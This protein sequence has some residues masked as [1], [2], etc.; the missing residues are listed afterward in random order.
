MPTDTTAPTLPEALGDA[1]RAFIAGPHRLLIG[2]ERPKAADGRT[3]ATLDPATGREIAH[4]PHAGPADVAGALAAARAA[5]ADGPW[6]SMPA[7]GRE[8]I[9]FALAQTIED[10]AQELAEIE[11]LDNG[12]PVNLARYVD[13]AGTIAHLRYF[14]GWPTK[15]EG[16]VLPVTAPNMHC[17]TR[18][19]PVGVCAQIV[20]W[21]F[22]L[23]MAAWKIAPALAAGC[24]VVLKPAEQTPL[25]ALRLGELALEAGL[26]PGVLNVLTGDGSTGAALVEHPEVDKIAFTGSTAVG[27]EIGSKAGQALKRVTLELGGK[28]PNI[29]LP[30]ADIDA[31]VRGAY[32]GIYFN[33]GQ[34][35]NAGSRLFIPRERFEEVTGALAEQAKATRLGPGLDGETQLGP[36]VSAE[37]RERVMGYI[38][39][40]REQGAEL[41][42]GGEATLAESGGYFVAPTLFAVTDDELKIAREEIFGPV[43]VASP[44]ETLEE[45]AARANDNEYGLAAGVWTRDVGN[46]HRLAAL[47]RA[48][49]VYVNTWGNAEPAV[50]F[51]GFKASGVGREH[52]Q[53]GLGAYLETKSVWTAL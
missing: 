16:A 15:I 45:V 27:R 37:Q 41:L 42:A 1:A 11:S 44:Y 26:P 32:Q 2:A 14:A 22:P 34:A 33:S 48:G 4:V 40:G 7:S 53:D 9:L 17:Y 23:M 8:R 21:N 3:F 18:R 30:D 10:H 25:S 29:I 31:A 28:S 13:V 50:P 52:G 35:C 5:F 24:T 51:G 36:V 38:E 46:A 20:P 6:A 49:M 19:E 39:S 43:L 12:K 47:L